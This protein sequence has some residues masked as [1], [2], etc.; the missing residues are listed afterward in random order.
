MEEGK[1]CKDLLVFRWSKWKGTPCRCD[2][3][4]QPIPGICLQPARPSADLEVTLPY[5]S[6]KAGQRSFYHHVPF[7]QQITFI[8]DAFLNK[9][10]R[11]GSRAPTFTRFM[12]A[13]SYFAHS[14]LLDCI[15]LPQVGQQS[16]GTGE[17]L[18]KSGLPR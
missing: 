2:E 9:R 1:T 10:S 13:E 18:F 7:W 12:P 16:L 4:E 3:E 17:A 8:P 15:Q 6:R 5:C 11:A 14:S